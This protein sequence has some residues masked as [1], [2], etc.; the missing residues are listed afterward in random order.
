VSLVDRAAKCTLLGR[1][2][3]KTAELVGSKMIVLLDEAPE[4]L[5]IT[6]DN[7]KEFADHTRVAQAHDAEFYFARPYHSWERGLNEHTN[8]LVREYFPK[9]TDF[10][11]VSDAEVRQ[12]QD[13]PNA[14]PRKALGYRTPMEALHGLE[15]KPP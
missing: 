8:G 2:E 9:G 10:R 14:R 1:V 3:R 6:S 11:L 15:V 7:G 13:R 12:V 4:V 5:T